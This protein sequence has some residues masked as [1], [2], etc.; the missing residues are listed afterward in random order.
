MWSGISLSFICISL[1]ISDVE[2]LIMCLLAICISCLEKYLFRSFAYFL[3]GTFV[4]LL[5]SCKTSLHI[6]ATNPLSDIWFVNT[7]SQTL[8][9]LFT[10]LIMTFEAKKFSTLMKSNLSFFWLLVLF[11]SYLRNHCQN[12]SH[13][14]L[15]VFF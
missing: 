14:D 13:K 6:V 7:F 15:P 2:N 9:C 3:I 12:R 10:F 1:M 5:L 11:M 8:G 4:F